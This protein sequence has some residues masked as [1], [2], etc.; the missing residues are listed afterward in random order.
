[1]T[2]MNVD[3]IVTVPVHNLLHARLGLLTHTWSRTRIFYV[4]PTMQL[5]TCPLLEHSTLAWTGWTLDAWTGCVNASQGFVWTTSQMRIRRWLQVSVL[6][7]LPN[8]IVK[9]LSVIRNLGAVTQ[10][11]GWRRYERS[12]TTT[13]Q[14]MFLKD[15]LELS[16]MFVLQCILP[17]FSVSYKRFKFNWRLTASKPS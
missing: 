17:E 2:R 11:N 12:E 3:V 14:L 7:G 9:I 13:L 10:N 15:S 6:V 5:S 1:M 8:Y 16:D 4:R